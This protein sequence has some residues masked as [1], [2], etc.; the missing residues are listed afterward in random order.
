MRWVMKRAASILLSLLF[1]MALPANVFAQGGATGAITGTVTDPTG[2]VVP[3][4]EVRIVNKGTGEVARVVKTE[5]SGVFNAPLLPVGNYDITVSAPGFASGTVA[6]VVVRI[7]ETT[8]MNPRMAPLKVL[9]KVEV[10]AQVQAVDTTTATT[11]ESV[12]ARTIRNLPLATQN[13]QQLLT[14][15]AGTNSDLNASASL[16]RGDVRIQVNGQREDNN[17]YLIEG[18]SATDYNVAELTNT[19]LPSPD[20]VQE[21]KVQ[22]SL[23]DATQG[24]NG[25]G[26]IN[27]ILK[28]GTRNFHGSVFEFFRNTDLDA[29]EWFLK[30]NQ[31][32]NGR[33]NQRPD[34]KQN[35]FGGSLGGPIGHE[36]KAGFFFVNYQGT[37]QRSGLST[38]AIISTVLPVLP[39]R[40]DA[41]SLVNTFFP[42]DPNV[43]AASF[44][45]VALKL[46]NFK[47]NQFNDPS[48]FLFPGVASGP[49]VLSKPGKYTDDQFTANYDRDFR[50][51]S[52][53]ISGRFF[54]SNFESLLPFG[55]GGLTA[56][57]GG[58]I[59]P[60]DLNFPLDLPVHDRF[61]SIA[62]THL[63]N[64]RLVNEF[65]F[66]YVH[67]NNRAIN[68]PII[69]VND[70]G[71]N[72]PNSNLYKTIYKFTFSTFQ[73]GPTPGADQSQLQNNLTF[74]DTASYTAGKHSLRFGGQYDRVNLDK[75]FPQTFNGQLFFFPRPGNA[76]NPADPCVPI[77]GCSDFQNFLLGQPGFSFGGRGVSNDEYRVNDYG[78]FLQDGYKATSNLTINAGLRWEL[79]G[80]AKD[81][82]CHI[83][84]TIS[85]LAN[86]G[87]S[88]FVYPKCV[89]KLGVPGFTGT[90]SNTTMANSYASHWG[91]RI[92]FAYDLF[93]HHTTAIRGG[94][95]IFYVRE[96]IGTV[97][98]LSFTA[99]ILPITT[100]L[101][102]PGDMADV[103]ATG[104]GR[105][106]TGGVIDPAF[107]P[108]YSQ[109]LG[110][111]DCTTG[112]P[113]LD[114]SQCAT[115]NNNSI[116]LFGLEVPRHFVS[117]STQQWNLSI[118]RQLPAN[119]VFEIG[120][121]GTKGTHLRETRD[122]I[123]PFDARTHPVTLTALNGTVYT[124]NQNTF[125]NANARSRALGLATQNYQL[126]A[127][128]AWSN[129]HSLQLT[130]SHRFS[131]A[132]YFQAAYTWSKALDATSSGNTA[133][134]TA[135][136]D[137]TN[138]RNSYG[139]SDFDRTHRLVISYNW[140]LP[141][142]AHSGG[143]ASA[144]LG[145]WTLSGITTF[146]SGT[147]FTVIDAGGGLGFNLSSP[148]T[149]TATLNP[150]FTISSA[151]TSGS[152]ESRIPNWFK[153]DATGAPLGTSGAPVIGP[154]RQTGFGHLGRNTFRG[155]FQQN[156]D[157]S[158]GKNFR[159]SEDKTFKVSADFFNIWNHPIFASPNNIFN[160]LGFGTITST[161][162]TPRLIQL[163]ARF[164]F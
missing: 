153:V 29:N 10:Q 36:G 74:L 95:G 127:S 54:F 129:Y 162:G 101:G 97:D 13:F 148:N 143:V 149:S 66:G 150:G 6:D 32:Q 18:I 121:V 112:A 30:Q 71:I 28:S 99:P 65:R 155:P 64:P 161:K 137:Q 59:S 20:V 19:P 4:A 31:V 117:P 1:L 87:I 134:N 45:P 151:Q 92:G 104:A 159:I 81:N 114:S 144:V 146:Q 108:V 90:L 147:P 73:L 77:G 106:P 49:F 56:T 5:P 88:P 94:Y 93:G 63:F 3:N 118:Q 158:L 43:T 72:R 138:L 89:D 152:V 131:R 113:T 21:F 130:T 47:S 115:F 27:A 48:G 33:S 79:F 126:F 120:Y 102:T 160:G 145:R 23:Y 140:D 122:S 96:D 116:N 34:I 22:T 44:D 125:F 142:F 103:F 86:Q 58:T 35:I 156:W 51:G 42:A 8:R 17:N 40:R 57:L 84:N 80:A 124:I 41:Q 110:F 16:G 52:D 141:F 128:D 15:S 11:G 133:F 91:P 7:T 107:I 82:L 61:L 139:P 109:F 60:T 100:P 157:V 136:N 24:R 70:L 105:L 119:W 55:A 39:S 154:V 38:G 62:E 111:I 98:Q 25:G 9:E 132:L 53:K 85:A 68:T 83:G 14:L 75:N 50:N 26:N 69:N 12:E 123:Q 37:R 76:T 163:S 46:L 164:A 78:L 135:I 67:I 2:A